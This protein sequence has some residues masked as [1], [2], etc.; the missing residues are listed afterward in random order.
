MVIAGLVIGD[1]GFRYTTASTKVTLPNFWEYAGFGVNT[2]IFLLVGI[3]VEPRLLL[4]TIPAALLAIEA[5][6]IG[7][8]CV[9]ARMVEPLSSTVLPLGI[10]KS[11]W[12]WA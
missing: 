12:G 4:Q 3:E 7:R 1:L 2:V 11:S 5:Y 8:I 10:I 6:Q 9:I